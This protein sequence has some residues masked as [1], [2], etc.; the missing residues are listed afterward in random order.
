MH[1]FVYHEN[2]ANW[3]GQVQLPVVALFQ[4]WITP[5]SDTEGS[6]KQSFCARSAKAPM[7]RAEGS[8][9]VARSIF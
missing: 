3:S 7:L 4:T 2:V 5:F 6:D 9:P 8:A 1:C